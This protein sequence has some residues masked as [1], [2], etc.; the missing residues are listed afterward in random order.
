MYRIYPSTHTSTDISY[1][2][3]PNVHLQPCATAHPGVGQP[4]L[5]HA[6]LQV[7]WHVHAAINAQE[8]L[9]EATATLH[10][11]R[12]KDAHTN[13]TGASTSAAC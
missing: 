9:Y 7:S 11:H 5:L 12:S 2:L 10:Q 1:P 8:E 3:G 6:V 4:P 13:M